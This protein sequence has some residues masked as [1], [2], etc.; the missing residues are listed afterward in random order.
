MPSTSVR[1]R[2]FSNR[3]TARG[4]ETPRRLI[5]GND[6]VVERTLVF[7]RTCHGSRLGRQSDGGTSS[8]TVITQTVYHADGN[9]LTL[10]NPLNQM[11]GS[12]A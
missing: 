1:P 5:D 12:A 6:D 10:V 9:R 3:H 2:S 8:H 4:R 11:Q 7:Q